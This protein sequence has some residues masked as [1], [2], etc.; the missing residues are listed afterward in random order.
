MNK[1]KFYAI[2]A[3]ALF[4]AACQQETQVVNEV[5]ANTTAATPK[6]VKVGKLNVQALT[7]EIYCTGTVDVPPM[8]RNQLHSYLAGQVTQINV[9]PGD[10]VKKGQILAKLS[11]PDLISL[12]QELLRAKA[13]MDFQ[14]TELDRKSKLLDNKATSVREINEIRVKRDLAKI[15]YTSSKEH[16]SL[17]GIE[18]EVVL[19]NG[20]VKEIILTAPFDAR[21]SKLWVT[22]GQYVTENQPLIEL[23]NKNHKHLEL[24]IFAKHA[25]KV[26]VGQKVSFNVPGSDIEYTGEIYLISPDI[27]DNRLR[28]HGHLDDESI[29]IKVGTFIEA[30]IVVTDDAVA[31]IA[32]EELI[33]EGEQFYLH[34][35]MGSGFERVEVKKGRSNEL[36][37]ELV[38]IDTT[39]N[40]VVAGNYY[41][42]EF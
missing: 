34:R 6:E 1:F 38:G 32:I 29:N 9:I 41:L 24:N 22:N 10:E 14:Q 4:I 11:H 35:P 25:E 23:L 12:Q 39:I 21:V 30:K 37:A 20:P 3:S 42:Q 40:W 2:L 5:P 31:Q 28:I 8:E 17:L 13:D 18:A 7:E 36:F 26:K 27:E 19:A 15:L 33:Q 16:L